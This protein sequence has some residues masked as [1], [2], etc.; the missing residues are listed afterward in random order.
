MFTDNNN[1]DSRRDL[2]QLLGSAIHYVE[3]LTPDQTTVIYKW[4]DP[5]ARPITYSFVID[6]LCGLFTTTPHRLAE[7]GVAKF[8]IVCQKRYRDLK[9]QL[10]SNKAE[11][12]GSS[13]IPRLETFTHAVLLH[14][15]D[16][17]RNFDILQVKKARDEQ[18]MQ[19]TPLRDFVLNHLSTLAAAAAGGYVRR[20][21]TATATKGE[22][23]TDTTKDISKGLDAGE[24]LKSNTNTSIQHFE[25]RPS[26]GSSVFDDDE[27]EKE[28]EDEEDDFS[29]GDDDGK[30]EGDG[31]LELGIST[32]L[33]QIQ[34]LVDNY[35]RNLYPALSYKF[36]IELTINKN[37]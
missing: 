34:N 23:Q 26:D 4:Y 10:T 21:T 37:P 5:I 15:S 1:N 33:Q 22:T 35:F 12:S 20:E 3:N 24:V 13:N 8:F 16:L 27:Q 36:K 7:A 17:A 25:K 31:N 28:D 11:G 18:Q 6:S 29:G 19:D 2:F 14:L 32:H 9:Q 30:D